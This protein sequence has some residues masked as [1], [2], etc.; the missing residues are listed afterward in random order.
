ME[1][2]PHLG[3]IFSKFVFCFSTVLLS[4]FDSRWSFCTSL[5][6]LFNKIFFYIL[7]YSLFIYSNHLPLPFSIF[8][9]ITSILALLLNTINMKYSKA[10]RYIAISFTKVF[11]NSNTKR[12]IVFTF[13]GPPFPPPI[14]SSCSLNAFFSKAFFF[15]FC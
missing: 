3:M 8:N 11:S 10:N 6:I 5:Y 9:F 4:G 13:F 1:L 2:W 7:F 12:P 14:R 15:S